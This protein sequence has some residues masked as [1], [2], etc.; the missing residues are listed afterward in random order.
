MKDILILHQLPH[1]LYVKILHII[2]RKIH[3]NVRNVQYMRGQRA[4]IKILLKFKKGI[5][6]QVIK[7]KL[8]FYVI[9]KYQIVMGIQ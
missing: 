7:V 3:P 4:V 5:G 8:S 2:L 1:V 6:D 9:I